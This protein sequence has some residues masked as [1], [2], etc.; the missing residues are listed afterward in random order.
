MSFGDARRQSM[1]NSGISGT[2]GAKRTVQFHGL[3]RHLVRDSARRNVLTRIES[4]V[5][6]LLKSL[7]RVPALR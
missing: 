4:K 6:W 3:R 5:M 7:R 2:D 1:A